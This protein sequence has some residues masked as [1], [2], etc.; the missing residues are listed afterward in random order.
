MKREIPISLGTC[1]KRIAGYYDL[2][3]GKVNFK[4][5]AKIIVDVLK[6]AKK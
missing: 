4:P 6:S 2:Q 3:T 1:S 5:E